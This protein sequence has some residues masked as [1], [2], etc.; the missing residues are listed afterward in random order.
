MGFLALHKLL[1]SIRREQEH[2]SLA[3]TAAV[4]TRRR[5]GSL[6]ERRYNERLQTSL[7]NLSISR[8]PVFPLF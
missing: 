7:N 3:L 6:Q 4:P 2:I 5:I 8:V 1:V